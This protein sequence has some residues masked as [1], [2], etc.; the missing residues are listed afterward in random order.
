MN[1][2]P[3]SYRIDLD[4]PIEA[5]WNAWTTREGI[6][7]FFAPDCNIELQIDGKYEMYFELENPLGLMGSE[8]MRIMAIEPFKLLAFSWNAPPEMPTIRSQRTHVALYFSSLSPNKT[9]VILVNS[10]YGNSPEW[11]TARKYFENAWGNVVLKRLAAYLAGRPHVW[12]VD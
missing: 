2:E 9:Q 7:S 1:I 4:A 3:I 11:R 5:V 12:G 10:G 8:G 6:V